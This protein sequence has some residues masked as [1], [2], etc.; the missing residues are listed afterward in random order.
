METAL[1]LFGL[2]GV[3]VVCGMVAAEISSLCS[4]IKRASV[5]LEKIQRLIERNVR[6]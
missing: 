1:I 5:A 2:A 3:C 6:P 4:A